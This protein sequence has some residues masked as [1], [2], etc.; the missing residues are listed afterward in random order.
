M[1]ELHSF[2][3]ADLSFSQYLVS[4]SHGYIGN[5][6]WLPFA[7]CSWMINPDAIDLAL[8]QD[9]RFG[10]NPVSTTALFLTTRRG[11]SYR[12]CLVAMW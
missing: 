10:Q 6:L 8:Q 7:D 4:R 12:V 1:Y 3:I 9:K 5:W 11:T 2:L